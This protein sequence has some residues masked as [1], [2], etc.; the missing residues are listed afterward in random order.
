MASVRPCRLLGLFAATARFSLDHRLDGVE[1][2]TVVHVVGTPWL[3]DIWPIPA[4]LS[5]ASTATDTSPICR[6]WPTAGSTSQTVGRHTDDVRSNTLVHLLGT[7]LE[8][9]DTLCTL[10]D[11]SDIFTSRSTITLS[12]FHVA[13]TTATHCSTA[14]PII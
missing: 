11:S 9:A 7:L 8:A 2:W 3:L 4:D 5:P 6:A 13:W 1:V 12:T 10:D 14:S